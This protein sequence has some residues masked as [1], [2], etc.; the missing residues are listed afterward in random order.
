MH[1]AVIGAGRAGICAAK[2]AL[3]YGYTVTVYEQT[4]KLGGTWVYTD[5]TGTDKNELNVHTSMYEGLRYIL[6]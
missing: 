4:G 5:E 6:Q 2:T 3:A 1:I